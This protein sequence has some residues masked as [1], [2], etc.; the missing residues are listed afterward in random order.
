MGAATEAAAAPTTGLIAAA[1]DE[2]SAAIAALFS[3]QARQFQ[4]VNRQVAAFHEQFVLT[5]RMASGLRC[6][7]W[8]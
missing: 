1:E 8:R 4:A 7:R 5:L 6:H 3:E 2:V